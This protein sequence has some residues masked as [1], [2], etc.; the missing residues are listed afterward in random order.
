M[1]L[2]SNVFADLWAQSPFLF[3]AAVLFICGENRKE[4][5]MQALCRIGAAALVILG[6]YL[7]FSSAPTPLSD[8]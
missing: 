2:L 8:Y 6:I 7:L 5:G 4:P 3:F 1:L